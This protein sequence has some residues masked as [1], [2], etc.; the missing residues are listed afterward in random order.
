MEWMP[1]EQ[2]HP[3]QAEQECH[4]VLSIMTRVPVPTST[5]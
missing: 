4:D 3:E 1:A 2:D 5:C